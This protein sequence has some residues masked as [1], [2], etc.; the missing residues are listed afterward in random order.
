MPDFFLRFAVKCRIIPPDM[1]DEKIIQLN[2]PAKDYGKLAILAAR[3]KMP[4]DTYAAA[5]T[6]KNE[7]RRELLE[8]GTEVPCSED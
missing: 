7:T 4:I 1:K 3:A 2:I 5:E 6:L 8:V